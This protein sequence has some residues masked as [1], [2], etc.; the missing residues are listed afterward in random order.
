MPPWASVR[1]IHA[2]LGL[3]PN[4]RDPQPKAGRLAIEVVRL[5]LFRPALGHQRNTP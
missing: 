2:E 1:A 3:A 5:C 4:P